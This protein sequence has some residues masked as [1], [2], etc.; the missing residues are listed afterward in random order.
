MNGTYIMILLFCFVLTHTHAHT[1]IYY[2]T[3]VVGL[4]FLLLTGNVSLVKFSSILVKQQL[5]H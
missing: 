4:Q 3:V 5:S 1:R 2:V